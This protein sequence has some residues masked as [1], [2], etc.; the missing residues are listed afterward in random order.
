M[1]RAFFLRHVTDFEHRA[2]RQTSLRLV[3]E[4][5]REPA[6]FRRFS[7][8]S[9]PLNEPARREIGGPAVSNPNAE[10]ILPI[11]AEAFLYKLASLAFLARG[12]LPQVA[13]HIAC[14]K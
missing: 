1:Q 4:Y 12:K 3:W 5:D 2:P 13:W 9:L 11:A 14:S 7:V 8:D 10:K 6:R